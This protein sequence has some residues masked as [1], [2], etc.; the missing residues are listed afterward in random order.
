[1]RSIS[2]LQ[3]VYKLQQV[4]KIDNLQQ[5]CGIFYLMFHI[6][7][8][9]QLKPSLEKYPSTVVLSS[10]SDMCCSKVFLLRESLAL[11]S[12]KENPASY[13]E[14][15]LLQATEAPKRATVSLM[16]ELHH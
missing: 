15:R 4:G 12:T 6:K 14:T 13:T 2:L 9:T 5:V 11:N 16:W 8:K 10:N 1:M 3:I 7:K